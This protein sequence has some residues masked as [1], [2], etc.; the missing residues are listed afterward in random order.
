ML[1]IRLGRATFN[2]A[3]LAPTSAP[4]RVAPAHAS[5]AD[6]HDCRACHNRTSVFADTS[7]LAGAIGLMPHAES[8]YCLVSYYGLRN[9]AAAAGLVALLL[10]AEHD[11]P[12][13]LVAPAAAPHS[14]DAAAAHVPLF[15]VGRAAGRTVLRA[16]AAAPRVAVLPR[17]AHGTA[18]P[19][20]GG[21]GGGGNLSL[22]LTQLQVEAPVGAKRVLPA[23]QALF[24]PS[25]HAAVQRP[26]ARVRLWQ[27]CMLIEY[28]AA[29]YALPSPF[30]LPPAPPA[31][32]TPRSP[33][34][35]PPGSP[36]P[37]PPLPPPAP[38]PPLP[39]PT[40]RRRRCGHLLS[41]RPQ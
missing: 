11:V 17:V 29:C 12:H 8:G 4:L 25:G 6:A 33:P 27:V 38:P 40:R 20:A 16:L 3:E 5:C 21:G 1:S 35:S 10:V 13:A 34:P 14:G 30:A 28:C 31:P 18:V 36:P 41:M 22:H 2:P 37:P 32:P 23:G 19:L 15:S 9:Q 39:P 26:V 7:G 24:N